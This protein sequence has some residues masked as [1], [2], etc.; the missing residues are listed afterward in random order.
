MGA[1]CP[2]ASEPNR[3]RGA[4]RR[5]PAERAPRRA[6]TLRTCGVMPAEGAITTPEAAPRAPAPPAV[7]LNGVTRRFGDVVALEALSLDVRPGEVVA[8]V[9]PSGCGKTTLLELVC[10]LTEPSSGSVRSS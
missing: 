1:P 6:P 10:G 8:V 3:P 4:G 2:I 7:A 5:R 9:G